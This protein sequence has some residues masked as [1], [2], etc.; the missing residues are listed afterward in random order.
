MKPRTVLSL[1]A[2]VG[3]TTLAALKLIDG[4]A[5]IGLVT[6]TLLASPVIDD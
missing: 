6:G 3:A 2:L 1:V 5:W 4:D